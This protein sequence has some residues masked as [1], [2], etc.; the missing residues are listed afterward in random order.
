[1]R[2]PAHACLVKRGKQI[3]L[4]TIAEIGLFSRGGL[5]CGNRIRRYAASTIATAH[6]P[7]R[8]KARIV[9]KPNK[10]LQ[11]LRIAPGKMALF[12]EALIIKDEFD[13]WMMFRC[14]GNDPVGI[15]AGKGCRRRTN[16][17]SHLPSL[18]IRL[19][20]LPLRNSGAIWQKTNPISFAALADRAC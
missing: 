2:R 19:P 18:D 7:D 14:E 9:G 13:R 16:S 10:R 3:A 15:L 8:I 6:E 1:M 12:D 20:K 17:S 4:V 5:Q 11:P